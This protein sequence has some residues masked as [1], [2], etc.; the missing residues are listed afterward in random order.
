MISLIPVFEIRETL[1]ILRVGVIVG[2][3]DL[4]LEGAIPIVSSRY[5]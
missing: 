1:E 2:K 4:R 5:A 3:G